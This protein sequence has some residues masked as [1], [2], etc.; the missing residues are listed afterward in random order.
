MAEMTPA[1]WAEECEERLQRQRSEVDRLR[2]YHEG[3]QPLALQSKKYAS[4]LAEMIRGV[5]DNWLPIVV[6]AVE[7]RLQVE[8]FRFGEDP[9]ADGDAWSMWQANNLD[10]DAALAHETALVTGR[11]MVLVWPADPWPEITVED[12][13]QCVVLYEA[14]SRRRRLA[15]WKQWTDEWTD[16]EFGTLYL[17][18]RLVRLR[19]AEGRTMQGDASAT[20]V[21]RGDPAGDELAHPAGVVP[22]VELRPRPGMPAKARSEIEDV[23]TTQDQI[24]KL[25]CDLLVASEY[26][27]FRQRWATGLEVPE[28][29]ETHEP[30]E[31]FKAAVDRLWVNPDPEG[32]FG[33][34]EATDLGNIV[35]AIENRTQ[36]LAS[37]TRTPPHYLLGGMGTWP[38]GESL[39]SAEAGLVAKVKR[40]S[41]HFGEGWEEVERLGFAMK[42]DDRAQQTSAETIWADPEYRT[43]AEHVDALVKLRTLDVP[44]RQL[45]EDAG[46]SQ[47]QIARFRAMLLEEAFTQLETTGTVGGLPVAGA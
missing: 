22:M 24:N 20:W 6:D 13:S 44:K 8:G 10:A 38:S 1:M 37:R 43:E 17:P 5:R 39:R 47:E 4:A 46:Y 16:A 21:L 14:G 11:C 12:P 25:V 29:P 2:L 34:F 28:D 3:R 31:P 36:S 35:K 27:S 33:D 40:R 26:A 45:W 18:D 9:G 23:L 42:G 41:V 32:R 15:A 7:E 19:K 30:V